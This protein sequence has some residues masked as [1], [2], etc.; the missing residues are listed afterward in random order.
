MTDYSS[1]CE[2]MFQLTVMSP[3]AD[4]CGTAS[5]RGNSRIGNNR[6]AEALAYFRGDYQYDFPAPDWIQEVFRKATEEEILAVMDAGNAKQGYEQLLRLRGALVKRWAGNR[7]ARAP[8]PRPAKTWARKLSQDEMRRRLEI[9]E[10]CTSMP[11][12]VA[13]T[14]LEYSTAWQWCRKYHPRLTAAQAK[15]QRRR[16]IRQYAPGRTVREV[17]ERFGLRPNNVLQMI[18]RYGLNTTGYGGIIIK[19]G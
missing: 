11:E 9:A 14:G 17:A 4:L 16:E 8:A 12:F 13:Q 2:F 19:Q 18:R 7:A 1:L 3:L 10:K 15:E 5:C 6:R